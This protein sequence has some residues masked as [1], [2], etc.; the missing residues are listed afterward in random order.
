SQRQAR[1]FY[2]GPQTFNAPAV[3][4]NFGG[5]GVQMYTHRPGHH[6]NAKIMM[7][8]RALLFLFAMAMISKVRGQES[9]TGSEPLITCT[10]AT[11][12]VHTAE[13]TKVTV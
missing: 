3:P 8:R 13:E 4:C 1:S 11:I 6:L 9:G 5:K 7:V 2:A 10:N 12:E